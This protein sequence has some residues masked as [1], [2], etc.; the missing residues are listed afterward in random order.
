M[1]TVYAKEMKKSDLDRTFLACDVYSR[2]KRLV[3]TARDSIT[4]Y[5]PFF[6]R[7]LLTLLDANSSIGAGQKTIVTDFTPR[8]LLGQPNQLHTIKKALSRG[9][10][11]LS[12]PRLHAKV[13]LTDDCLVT[14]G[15]QNFTSYGR[16]SKETSVVP[17]VDLTGSRLIT[18]LIEWRG[19]AEKVDAD[20]VDMLISKLA[21]L[22]RQHKKLSKDT[23]STFDEIR[24][25]QEKK[26]RA[27]A[28]Q[29]FDELARQSRIRMAQGSVFASVKTTIGKHGKYASLLADD[30]SDMTKWLIK[31]PDGS[32]EEYRLNRLSIYPMILADSCR[33]G[34][35]RIGR[36]RITY[37]RNGLTWTTRKLQVGDLHMKVEITFPDKE[38]QKRN[39]IVKL[40][41]EHGGSCEFGILFTG[42]SAEVK[43][44]TYS[45]R[46]GLWKHRHF[47]STLKSKFF[48]SPQALVV[49]QFN[50]EGL[51]D[52]SA[53]IFR[54]PVRR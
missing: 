39:I 36:T 1:L 43:E 10:S 20:L 32:L 23:G 54:E 26:K 42:R 17:S 9:I 5:T 51:R 18:T 44:K 2:W 21:P 46:S 3:T 40:S 48:N 19:Q 11:V 47:V 35:A 28:I 41:H 53:A 29:H 8:A 37:I 50:F 6:D 22:I 13:L 45:K 34:F 33:M 25:Q 49:S 31:T 27:T 12:L 4:I 16:K 15:S 30:K 38:T 24:E 7:L 14:I 52:T